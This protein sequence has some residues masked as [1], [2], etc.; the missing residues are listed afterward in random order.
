ME[1]RLGDERM[2]KEMGWQDLGGR[3]RKAAAYG[4][5]EREGGG[6]RREE[7]VGE[8]ERTTR[9]LGLQPSWGVKR[10]DS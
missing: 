6:P 2:E 1:K 8:R 4:R 3:E 7:D 5:D 10:D 9:R